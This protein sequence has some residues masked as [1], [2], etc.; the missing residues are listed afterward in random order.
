MKDVG[1]KQSWHSWR[2]YPEFIWMYWGR[3]G[4]RN[5]SVGI[6]SELQ[7]GRPRNHGSIPCRGEIFVLLECLKTGCGS[8][9]PSYPMRT[10]RYF[11]WR[12]PDLFPPSYAKVRIN[13]SYAFTKCSGKLLREAAKRRTGAIVSEIWKCDLWIRKG[14]GR[15]K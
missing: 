12:K 5:D 6:M 10:G 13:G 8:H 3:L 15:R 4:S 9:P 1:R 14:E 7:I 11:P 2:H